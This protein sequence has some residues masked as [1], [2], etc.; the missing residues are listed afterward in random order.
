MKKYKHTKNITVDGRV[1]KI[2]ADT[3]E[4][5]AVKEYKKRQEL[6]N[7]IRKITRSILV[8]DWTEE[9]M[10]NYK[11]PSVSAETFQSYSNVI[12]KHI[13]P[14][15]GNMRI[16][17]VK[18]IHVQKMVN[19]LSGMSKKMI[20][21][22]TQLTWSMF[23]AAKANDLVIDNPAERIKKPKGTK[24]GRRAITDTERRYTLQL[25]ETHPAG[26]LVKFS[27][28][29][30]LRPGETC[31]LQ[32][33]HID[34]SKKVLHVESTIKRCGGVGEPKTSAGIRVVPIPDLFLQDLKKYRSCC[35]WPTDP[36]DYILRNN[37]GGRM[38]ANVIRSRWQSFKNDLNI[39][40]GC[41]SIDGKAVPPYR[42]ADD[43]V[44]YCYRHTY[45]TDLQ[46]AGVPI[47]IAKDLMGHADI[48][49]TSKIYTHSTEK[50][51]NSARQL[52]NKLHSSD[53]V[54]NT[55]SEIRQS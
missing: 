16:S 26:M 10:E 21:R 30:G 11:R 38:S 46:D 50:S 27:L 35:G 49:I 51:F 17:A 1:Y 15:I 3:K 32:W 6:E 43:L 28:Y 22:V 12:R 41:D 52:I 34:F 7:G 53:N 47:N 48:S 54:E 13:I 37:S 44:L 40:M 18:P 20:D 19:R 4:E 25:A 2:R 39:L 45:C 24:T 31:A 8:R 5:L 33:R 9:W 14:E 42:V 36:F 23:D 55:M 29:C